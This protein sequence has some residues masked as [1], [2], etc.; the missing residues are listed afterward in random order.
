MK[1]K[2]TFPVPRWETDPVLKRLQPKGMPCLFEDEDLDMGES[3]VHTLTCGILFYGLKLYFARRKSIRVFAN[4]NLYYSRQPPYRYVSP[5]IMVIQTSRRYPDDLASYTIGEDGPAPVFVAEVL[6]YHTW[7][8]GD[9]GTKPDLYADLGVREYAVVDVTGAFMEQRLALLHR[10]EDGNWADSVSEDGKI[11]SQL[12][13]RL[14]VDGDGHLRVFD[15]STDA[16]YPRPD[17]AGLELQDVKAAYEK[18]VELR[19]KEVELRRRLEA[20]LAQLRRGGRHKN[21]GK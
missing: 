17:E 19:R 6:S 7:Q 2:P 21:G 18:E 11:D 3:V 1:T 5:D 8:D 14:R 13:F 15:S 16:P 4:L 10:G 12:G 20:E 9:L